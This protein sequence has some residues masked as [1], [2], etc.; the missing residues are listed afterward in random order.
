MVV[1]HHQNAQQNDSL[2]IGNKSFENV[3]RFKYL[4][5]TVTNQNCIYKNI[6]SDCI[7][8]M[9]ATLLFVVSCLPVLS[10]KLKY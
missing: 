1:S 6:K 10:L 4:G 9:L 8:R 5:T 7:Q 3:A 2:L